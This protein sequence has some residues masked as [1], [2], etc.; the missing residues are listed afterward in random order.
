MQF[1]IEDIVQVRL[2]QAMSGKKYKAFRGQIL[3]GLTLLT[4]PY[5]IGSKIIQRSV[6]LMQHPCLKTRSVPL[7]LTLQY[8]GEESHQEEAHSPEPHQPY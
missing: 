2:T 7:Q 4:T 8:K 5:H 1:F 3:F 6:V